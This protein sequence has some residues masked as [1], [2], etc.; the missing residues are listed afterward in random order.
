MDREGS[1]TRANR[2]RSPFEGALVI[3]TATLCV[4]DGG[5]FRAFALADLLGSKPESANAATPARRCG[6]Y[7]YW[8]RLLIDAPGSY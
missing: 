4:F 2:V 1:G 5:G 7:D 8:H 3:L 6:G